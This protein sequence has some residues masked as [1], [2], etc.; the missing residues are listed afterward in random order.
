METYYEESIVVK[1]L[2]LTLM[3]D[4]LARHRKHYITLDGSVY[5]YWLPTSNLLHLTELD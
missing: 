4:F 2:W 1:C 5:T 3:P